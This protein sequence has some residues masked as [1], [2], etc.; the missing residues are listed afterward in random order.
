M[1][2][3]RARI[4]VRACGGGD[5]WLSFRREEYVPK[6][7]AEGGDGGRG[8]DV[9]VRC[10]DRRATGSLPV[11]RALAG[12]AWRRR[13]ARSSTARTATELVVPVPPGTQVER[14]GRPRSIWCGP[15]SRSWWPAAARAGAAT[16]ASPPLRQAP[17]LAEKGEPGEEGEVV[18][19]LKV[20]ADVGL[21]GFPNAGKSTILA[22]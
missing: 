1:L 5:G 15:A 12:R 13:A 6:G 8:G 17:R 19:E 11:A 21:V 7:D 18:L 9:V 2:A 16:S 3:Y 20:I 10:D 14:S 22:R 4:E